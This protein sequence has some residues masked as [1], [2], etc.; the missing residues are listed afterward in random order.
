[1]WIISDALL[2]LQHA[3]GFDGED[4]ETTPPIDPIIQAIEERAAQE[5][6][7]VVGSTLLD[8]ARR[9]GDG[10]CDM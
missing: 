2:L 3:T 10:S 5:A 6:W 9:Y 4:E 1:M 8:N 7:V